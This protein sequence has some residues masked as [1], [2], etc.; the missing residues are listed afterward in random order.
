MNQQ[1]PSSISRRHFLRHAGGGAG[2]IGLQSLLSTENG[3]AGGPNPLPK[4]HFPP[5]AK[6]IIWLFMH[7]G[8]SHVDLFDPKPDLVKYAG[9]SLPESFGTVMTRRKVANNP[10]LGPI[11]PFRPRGQSG[12]EISDFLP[13]LSTVADEL[14]VIRSLHGDSVNHPQSVYQMNTGSIL[15]GHP[16][17]GSWL[18]Y[19]L[20]SENENMPAFVVLPDP[21][22]GLKGGPS[23]WG[24]GFLPATYQGTTMRPGSTP[25]LNLAA[26]AGISNPRQR[27]TLD[28]IEQ[29]NRRHLAARGVDDELEA[30][31]HSYELA[32]R[33]QSAAPEAVDFSQETAQTLS[34]YGI[35]HPTTRD[36]GQRCLLARRLIERGVRVVQVYS[37]DTNG[38]DAHEDV[39]KNHTEYCAKTD[40]PVAALLKDL[41]RTGLLDDTL[42]VWC[43]E[44]GRMPMSEK[45]KG[46]DHNPWGYSGWIA[47]AGTRGGRA[48]GE[49][50]EVGLRAAVDTVHVNQ[51]HASLL[52]LMGMD[53]RD[54]TYFHNGLDERLTGPAEVDVIEELIS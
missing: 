53:H 31:I 29:L 37:G 43:G 41:K 50:D 14:C 32:F 28:F 4:T 23:A 38:W 16:S 39:A 52:H 26:P 51:F 36:Y 8:P 27:S 20:G 1:L 54:L 9:K 24:N 17:F 11:R 42:V 49:T 33:M 35:D 48:H 10:L 30:R 3:L 18:S 21:G 40:Q 13:H 12:L 34:M 22:G 7:G 5:R 44:F 19:G 2:L 25:I 6:R 46:R 47:G 15:M 45:G